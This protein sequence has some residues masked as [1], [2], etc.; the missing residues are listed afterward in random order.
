MTEV[1]VSATPFDLRPS[2]K[3]LP[4]QRSG[5]FHHKNTPQYTT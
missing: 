1:K 5:V 2:E 4:E 3:E